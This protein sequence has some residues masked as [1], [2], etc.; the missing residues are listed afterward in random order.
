MKTDLE[1]EGVSGASHQVPALSYP[2]DR[3]FQLAKEVKSF[4]HSMPARTPTCALLLAN[5]VIA[6]IE[7]R[8]IARDI[9]KIDEEMFI[10]EDGWV[11][12]VL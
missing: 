10:V 12:V 6:V 9:V 4:Y 8:Q 11:E 3:L 2:E 5:L 7:E 1:P